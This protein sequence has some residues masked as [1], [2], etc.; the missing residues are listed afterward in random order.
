MIRGRAP[1]V[2]A[3]ST[4][5]RRCVGPAPP[6][7]V[8]ASMAD[9]WFH[10]RL[11][12]DVSC[13]AGRQHGTVAQARGRSSALLTKLGCPAI[14][15]GPAKSDKQAL[16][17]TLAAGEAPRPV[18]Q[19]IAVRALRPSVARNLTRPYLLFACR[20]PFPS[21]YRFGNNGRNGA[22]AM[23]CLAVR[24][25]AAPCPARCCAS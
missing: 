22:W 17:R 2:S 9:T 4:R 13:N 20:A 1:R 25:S 19:L 12:C 24:C 8:P 16:K 10:A 3:V 15:F 18:R 7:A 14:T 23:V 6:T 5:C 11:D 21:P